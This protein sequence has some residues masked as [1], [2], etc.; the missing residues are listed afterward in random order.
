MTAREEIE[1]DGP[2]DELIL[3]IIERAVFSGA[4]WE[5]EW[6][7]QGHAGFAKL[8]LKHRAAGEWLMRELNAAGEG[9]ESSPATSMPGNRRDGAQR[10]L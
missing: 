1:A 4:Y 3:A 6:Q 8:A 10:G 5:L 2:D 9:L 7:F